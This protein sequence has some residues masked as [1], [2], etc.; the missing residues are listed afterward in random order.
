MEIQITNTLPPDKLSLLSFK[1]FYEYY[2]QL[3]HSGL[4][5]RKAYKRTEQ[6][7]FK[8]FQQK[9]YSTFE[10]FMRVVSTKINNKK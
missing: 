6:E 8:Y 9:K 5:Q 2:E 3:W 1:G 7:Y 4:V 10:S